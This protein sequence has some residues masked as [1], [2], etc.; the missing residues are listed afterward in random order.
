MWERVEVPVN[1]I[2]AGIVGER[3]ATA[4]LAGWDYESGQHEDAQ[5]AV[6]ASVLDM[7]KNIADI[8]ADGTNV[9]IYGPPGTGK[10]HLMTC[11]FRAT[12]MA[13]KT[14]GFA[15]GAD[16]WGATRDLIDGGHREAD[17]LNTIRRHHVYGISDPVPP[18]TSLTE[19]QAAWLY[20]IIDKRY[21]DNRP[22]WMTL[23]ATGPK[24]AIEKLTP[25]IY[26]RV[27]DGA[28]TIHCNWPSYR[29]RKEAI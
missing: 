19:F 29:K 27:R 10:D 3:Y 26:D 20:R 8:I 21:R 5:R 9:L 18:R 25:Q 2:L 4:T 1:D 11:L 22:V 16:L 14:V 23:N 6:V 17:F 13:G 12:L 28:I 15:V 7:C 24:D